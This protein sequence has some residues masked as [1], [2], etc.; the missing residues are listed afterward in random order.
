[1]L[2]CAEKGW[3]IFFSF[4]FISENT[5]LKEELEKTTYGLGRENEAVRI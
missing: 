2:H 3:R 1:M 4:M 5:I